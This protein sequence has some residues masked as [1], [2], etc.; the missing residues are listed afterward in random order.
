MKKLMIIALASWSLG[1]GS[2]N[3]DKLFSKGITKET[4]R[5]ESTE[6]IEVQQTINI[7]DSSDATMKLTIWPKGPFTFSA[8]NGFAGEAFKM[9]VKGKHVQLIQKRE[10]TSVKRGSTSKQKLQKESVIK[11]KEKQVK[12]EGT[13]YEVGFLLLV[14]LAIVA[15]IVWK[16]MM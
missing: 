3:K 15:W 6:T 5:K 7:K 1:C 13:G 16:K 4:L 9:E 14:V 11:L 8:A 10:L 12:W 2:L